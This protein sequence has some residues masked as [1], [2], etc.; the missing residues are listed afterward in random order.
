MSME[1]HWN[2]RA[3][4]AGDSRENP[5]TSGTVR[6]SSYMGATSPGIES[7]SHRWDPRERQT[8]KDSPS[9]RVDDN[10]LRYLDE[11][12]FKALRSVYLRNTSTQYPRKKVEERAGH[13]LFITLSTFTREALPLD[14]DEPKRFPRLKSTP[15]FLRCAL[16]PRGTIPLHIFF[17]T[18]VPPPSPVRHVIRSDGSRG[19]LISRYWRCIVS[20]CVTQ[21]A[22]ITDIKRAANP[23]TS[24]PAGKQHST[25]QGSRQ[26]DILHNTVE[27][28][29]GEN[30]ELCFLL[31][32]RAATT[33]SN[34]L[35]MQD[36]MNHSE[37][38]RA[39]SEPAAVVITSAG[40]PPLRSVAALTTGDGSKSNIPVVTPGRTTSSEESWVAGQRM[41][42]KANRT[43]SCARSI[44]VARHGPSRRQRSSVPE[45]VNFLLCG[46][47][48]MLISVMHSN[49][50][51]DFRQ[52]YS[53]ASGS[54][55]N[56]KPTNTLHEFMCSVVTGYEII[57]NPGM[58]IYLL[59]IVNHIDV[60][61]VIIVDQNSKLINFINE[62]VTMRIT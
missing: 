59:V 8:W 3:G 21:P 29:G 62:E 19:D 23:T 26:Q 47:P 52:N 56:G 5:L 51:I 50:D 39:L 49:I 61:I 58:L 46:Y 4:R 12:I 6:H 32:D 31:H 24:R 45:N 25:S 15:L 2:T 20:V 9:T 28:P 36:I 16:L 34:D 35:Y 37:N 11:S 27:R 42:E 44:E 33:E 10:H 40:G 7:G 22:N 18:F 54:F 30:H 43:A 14:S 1:L 53:I 38:L 55:L 17:K 60:L 13:L 57:E 48:N 41:T